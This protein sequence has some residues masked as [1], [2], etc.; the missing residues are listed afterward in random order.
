MGFMHPDQTLPAT[1]DLTIDGC[2][3]IAI[4]GNY[5]TSMPGIHEKATD[6]INL[7]KHEDGVTGL[8]ELVGGSEA[9]CPR[10][11]DADRETGAFPRHP[12]HDPAFVRRTVDDGVLHVLDSH[13]VID[14]AEGTRTK[15]RRPSV[16]FAPFVAH[17]K[18]ISLGNESMQRD[19]CL[20]RSDNQS[21]SDE[22]LSEF[23]RE[24]AVVSR[25]RHPNIVLYLGVAINPPK[26]CLV[27]KYMQSGA[28]TDLI[29]QRKATPIDSFSHHARDRDGTDL[30][31]N[32]RRS[33][34][35]M[36][37]LHLR[38]IMHRD[39]KSGNV[40]FDAYGT[41]KISD[42]GLS[43][44]LEI[45]HS[46]DQSQARSSNFGE[47][48]GRSLGQPLLRATY[49]GDPTSP[50]TLA[51]IFIVCATGDAHQGDMGSLT[52][53]LSKHCAP[54]K[55]VISADPG[56][57]L[58]QNA[59]SR[60]PDVVVIPNQSG[61]AADKGPRML[62]EV[63]MHRSFPEAKDWI[64]EYFPM[65]P[66]LRTAIAF[67]IFGPLGGDRYS[68]GAVVL[69]YRRE[70][71]DPVHNVPGPP[72]LVYG[73]SIGTAPLS[74]QSQRDMTTEDLA[75][76]CEDSGAVPMLAPYTS[77]G[78]PGMLR[79]ASSASRRYTSTTAPNE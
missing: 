5:V 45:G 62:I 48:A 54:W 26:Y 19:A 24:V 23:Y 14:D 79:T 53:Q 13:R 50:N 57:L 73:A 21:L 41:V 27:F 1:P 66:S 68:F 46:S 32:W 44:V 63:D 71:D 30:G 22:I 67:K 40:L 60:E 43:C 47:M 18:R 8:V 77:T 36:N 69:V 38:S 49:K 42:F 25:L 51:S 29:R 33:S 61:D 34:D 78:G 52:T 56:S 64:K 37:Y 39:L 11:H 28:L 15:P 10:A 76:L 2:K 20:T 55:N 17:N 9:R 58:T 31:G 35:G 59:L 7:L 4:D 65:L 72:V 3:N 16:C 75:L 12:G 70:P 74:S 6:A